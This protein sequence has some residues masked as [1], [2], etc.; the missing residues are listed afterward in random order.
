[1]PVTRAA[2]APRFDLGGVHFLGFTAPSRGASELCTWQLE[3]D[4]GAGGGHPH[5]LSREEVF[6][7]LQGTLSVV[8]DGE[9][10]EL[11]S[12]DALAVP[13]NSLLDVANHGS[14]TARALVCVPAGFSAVYADGR[15]IGTPPWAL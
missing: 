9:E 12:G 3:I 1:M 14:Q 5:R 15:A 11:A 8:V 7:A 2:Q 10:I 6:I 13:A 4:P